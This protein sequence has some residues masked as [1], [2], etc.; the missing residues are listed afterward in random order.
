MSEVYS[1]D[2]FDTALI[3][4]TAYPIDLFYDLART[5]ISQ[6][7]F[8]TCKHDINHIALLRIKA[9]KVARRTLRYYREDIRLSDIYYHFSDLL[10]FKIDI[11]TAMNIEL[12]LEMQAAR[13]NPYVARIIADARRRGVSIL[14][15]S[16]MYLPTSFIRACLIKSGL[17]EQNDSVYVSG[18]IGLSKHHGS[19][20]KYVLDK[21]GVL[22]SDISHFGDNLYSDIKVPSRFG[23]VATYVG[24][25]KL[26]EYERF[27]VKTDLS[28]NLSKI[29]G[30]QR[31]IR[32]KHGSNPGPFTESVPVVT[33]LIAPVLTA[34]TAWV[35]RSARSHGIERLYFVSRDGE[36]LYKI[37]KELS[38]VQDGP[39]IK[40]LYGSRQ[41][42]FLPSILGDALENIDWAFSRNGS[43]A[44]YDILARFNF[45]RDEVDELLCGTEFGAYDYQSA[46]SVERL[47]Q[48]RLFVLHNQEIRVL[49]MDKA[50]SALVNVQKY[51]QQENLN[52]DGNWAI[53]DVGWRLNCQTALNR[54]FS[55][56]GWSCRAKGYY[57]GLAESVV[58]SAAEGSC[59]S[60]FRGS[61]DIIVKRGLIIEHIF[62]AS[63]HSSVAGYKV[64]KGWTSPVFV[65]E[66]QDIQLSAYAEF[67]HSLCLEF[68]K[69]SAL[70]GVWRNPDIS[71]DRTI[72]SAVIR[73]LKYPSAEA[74]KSIN[75]VP[76]V[77]DQSHKMSCYLKIGVPISLTN[78]LNLIRYEMGFKGN[79]QLGCYWVEGA[80]ALSPPW[81][82]VIMRSLLFGQRL[83]N[84]LLLR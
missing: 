81:I 79:M 54:I 7:V 1:F 68:A 10:P 76:L 44:I 19:L 14:F 15:I 66:S 38:V 26:T 51:F 62:T 78:L 41:A 28:P 32:L 27:L 77:L 72:R 59:H 60:Y 35:L 39:E 6:F 25:A 11:Q 16:D 29:V 67:L 74:V 57:L 21:E 30:L 3:R 2:V 58:E 24:S 75:W 12:E 71:M 18:D 33:G 65:S 37:A 23:I 46:L 40:Y 20:Y 84:K 9:E 36:I 61:E 63:T 52:Q 31:I 73:F 49:I 42:W 50:K 22:P 80:I 8:D 70:L 43:T 69:E 17:A 45:S 4:S 55:S 13:P 48:F 56:L 53:V 83:A 64:S 5:L 34:F 47:E 82:R